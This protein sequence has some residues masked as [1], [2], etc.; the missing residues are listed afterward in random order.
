MRNYTVR[1]TQDL[2]PVE[3]CLRLGLVC[4][5]DTWGPQYG[6][7]DIAVLKPGLGGSDLSV[8][9]ALTALA[10]SMGADMVQMGSKQ[11]GRFVLLPEDDLGEP[12]YARPTALPG[13]GTDYA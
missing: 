1:S 12:D 8:V 6:S 7:P 2:A 9:D 4:A 3:D 13:S 5:V 10:S 11:S